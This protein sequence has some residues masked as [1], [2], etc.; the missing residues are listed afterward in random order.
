MANII[1]DTIPGDKPPNRSIPKPTIFPESSAT[2]I[3]SPL[4]FIR[5][6]FTETDIK[7]S[8]CCLRTGGIAFWGM[9]NNRPRWKD[10]VTRKRGYGLNANRGG[11]NWKIRNKR[12]KVGLERRGLGKVNRIGRV[13]RFSVALFCSAMHETELAGVNECYKRSFDE[14]RRIGTFREHP[15]YVRTIQNTDATI[16]FREWWRVIN[17]N[18]GGDSNEC[19]KL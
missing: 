6:C 15:S 16:P 12:T 19:N 10:R 1:G 11:G 18:I 3:K 4:L 9:R 17:S 7:R 5:V 13:S 14:F 8:L 2:P